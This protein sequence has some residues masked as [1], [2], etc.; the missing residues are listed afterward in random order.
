MPSLEKRKDK[1]E[2]FSLSEI[3]E[4]ISAAFS[5]LSHI[6]PNIS[7]FGSARTQP[8]HKHYNL[9]YQI[10]AGL[11][12]EGYN[13]ITGGGPGLMEAASKGAK[14]GRGLSIGLHIELPNE[15]TQ[16]PYIDK[17]FTFQ[18][19]FIRKLIFAKYSQ[20]YIIMPG[21]MGTLDELSEAFVLTQTAKISPFPLIFVDRE[22]WKGFFDWL[23]NSMVKNAYIAEKELSLAFFADSSDEVLCI[24]NT[25]EKKHQTKNCQTKD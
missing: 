22:Y 14:E 23:R 5:Q 13:I 10:A 21:G 3:T 8:E 18:H 20:A 6:S 15:Q 25:F 2:N 1:D 11:S 19:F 4:E 12:K 7:F 16:N 24:I 9:A 17:S